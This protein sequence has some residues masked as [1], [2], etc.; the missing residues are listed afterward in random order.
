MQEYYLSF[1]DSIK[2]YEQYSSENSDIMSVGVASIYNGP[3][4]Q[5]L[6]LPIVGD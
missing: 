4:H 3:N 2:W 6:L 5:R 1:N